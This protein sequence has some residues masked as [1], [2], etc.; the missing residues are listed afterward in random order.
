MLLTPPVGR[1]DSVGEPG[2]FYDLIIKIMVVIIIIWPLSSK[3]GEENISW[4][5]GQNVKAHVYE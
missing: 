3:N 1:P 2:F 4:G 5:D